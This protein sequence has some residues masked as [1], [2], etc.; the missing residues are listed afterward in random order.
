MKMTTT[1]T[2]TMTVMKAPL[3]AAKE[4]KTNRMTMCNLNDHANE[5]IKLVKM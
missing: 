3:R 5:E 4:T 1:M 2:I